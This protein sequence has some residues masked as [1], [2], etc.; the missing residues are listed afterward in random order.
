MADGFNGDIGALD[1]LSRALQ[2]ATDIVQDVAAESV[3]ELRNAVDSEFTLGA[4]P[5]GANWQPLAE[6]TKRR[7]P[8]RDDPP[9]TDTGKMR[10]SLQV[11]LAPQSI[12]FSIDGPAEYHQRGGG[13]LPQRK[14]F[15]NEGE[16]LPDAWAAAIKDALE[17]VSARWKP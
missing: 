13:R 1:A 11:A 12:L 2:G 15:P 14:I 6:S 17:R 10:G 8:W 16:P 4:D 9:L 5:Y 3:I 7:R